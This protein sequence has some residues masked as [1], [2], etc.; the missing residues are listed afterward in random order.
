MPGAKQLLLLQSCFVVV[1]DEIL[2]GSSDE[3]FCVGG[4]V[5]A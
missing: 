5:L 3:F 4:G 2:A 1:A